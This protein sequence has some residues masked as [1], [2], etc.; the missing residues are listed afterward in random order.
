MTTLPGRTT[1]TTAPAATA[2]TTATPATAGGD[3]GP[4]TG[5]RPVVLLLPGQGAQYEGMAV[6]LYDA[7]PVFTA[8]MDEVFE[9]M[10]PEGRRVRA[11][12][13]SDRP[14]VPLDDVTRAQALLFAVDHALARLVL[15][16]G[17]RPAA[18]LGHSVGEVVGAVL[19]GVLDLPDAVRLQMDRISRISAAPPGG[20][21]A[22]AARRE[23][24][25]PYLSEQVVVGVVN[26]ARQCVLAG[27]EAE[28]APVEAGLRADGFLCRRTRAVQGFHSPS[29]AAAAAQSLPTVAALRLSPP[30]PTLFSGYT[31]GPLSP[32]QATDPAFWA[33]QP[34]APVLFGP[35]LGRLLDTG[36]YVLVE[37]GPG[38]GLTALARRRPAVS[39]GRS[40]A[41][42]TLPARRGAPA[43]DRRTVL[44]A[45]AFLRAEGHGSVPAEPAPA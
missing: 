33:G 14:A 7:E 12:W 24:L 43:D 37:A 21:L 17:V 41:V 32:E 44:A 23:E 19:T 25:A 9:L 45:A 10:G 3:D 38:Q 39:S 29:L 30:S 26:G 27:P 4:G 8:A 42:P 1:A 34:A 35:A 15:S 20:M 18:V 31:A 6:G 28:L 11:D 36:R 16:W 13:L 22:V 5:P 2:A 40:A